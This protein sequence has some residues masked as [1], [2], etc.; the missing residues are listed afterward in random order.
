MLYFLNAMIDDLNLTY[1]A[2]IMTLGQGCP[3]GRIFDIG[4][5]FDVDYRKPKVVGV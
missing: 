5:T 4:S 1:F 3:V 2:L